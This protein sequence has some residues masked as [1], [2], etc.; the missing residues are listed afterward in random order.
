MKTQRD[1]HR[2]VTP[3]QT[4]RI[5]VV[6]SLYND[7]DDEKEPGRGEFLI[8]LARRLACAGIVL[9]TSHRHQKLHEE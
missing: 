8:T 9:N 2:Y 3:V 6:Y 5:L 1:F 4:Y 7:D